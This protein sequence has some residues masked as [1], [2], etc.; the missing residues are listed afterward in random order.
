MEH[1]SESDSTQSGSKDSDEDDDLLVTDDKPEAK[2]ASGLKINSVS[3]IKDVGESDSDEPFDELYQFVSEET[4][5]EESSESSTSFDSDEDFEIDEPIEK[6]ETNQNLNVTESVHLE[7]DETDDIVQLKKINF[8]LYFSELH[9]EILFQIILMF[10]NYV[11]IVCTAVDAAIACS[12]S[13]E[14][15][16]DYKALMLS[17]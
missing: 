7:L 12:S 2:T 16:Q 4:S 9:F 15:P 6:A 1:S 14:V 13:E 11:A 17:R 8:L 5:A 10:G 3:I